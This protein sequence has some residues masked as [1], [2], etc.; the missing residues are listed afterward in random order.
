MQ[1]DKPPIRVG[2]AGFGAF[3]AKIST[4]EKPVRHINWEFITALP[5]FQMYMV[6]RFGRS[7]SDKH[8]W[9][10]ERAA[11]EVARVGDKTLLDHYVAWHKAKGYWPNEDAYGQLI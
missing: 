10:I 4:P 1:T 7:G 9:A 3:I 5:P 6:E 2:V 11:L 8:E